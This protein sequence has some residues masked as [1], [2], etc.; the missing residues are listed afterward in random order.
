MSRQGGAAALDR[1]AAADAGVVLE[2]QSLAW[3]LTALPRAL[4]RPAAPA[5]SH[6]AGAA[7]A[8]AKASEPAANRDGS[9]PNMCEEDPS[10]DECRCALGGGGH[11]GPERDSG[12][13]RATAANVTGGAGSNY[14]DHNASLPLC[15]V[16][17][18]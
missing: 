15:S 18:D 13:C 9:L 1:P 7:A 3:A 10:A 12:R 8:H 11:C 16:Y 6:R 5:F 14:P 4:W 2:Q 17:D